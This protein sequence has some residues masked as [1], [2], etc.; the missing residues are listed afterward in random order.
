MDSFAQI[1]LRMLSAAS[2]YSTSNRFGDETPFKVQVDFDIPL[3]EGNIDV[4]ALD[5][6]LNVLEGYFSVHNFFDREKITLVLLKVVPHVQNWWGN[7]CEQN[8]SDESGMFETNLTWAS[9]IDVAREKYYPVGNYDDHY[10][11]WTVL[12]E[13]RNKGSQST[14]KNFIPCVQS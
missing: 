3:F 2:A 10:T 11:K 8:S 1:L 13:E 6:W 14:P 9:F 5:N 4:D 12:C 7:F